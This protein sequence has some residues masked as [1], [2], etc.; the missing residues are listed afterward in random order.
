[1][2]DLLSTFKFLLE[3]AI[4]L[5]ACLPGFDLRRSLVE[6]RQHLRGLLSEFDCLP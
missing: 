3:L 1:M 2:S 4:F 5:F 6:H